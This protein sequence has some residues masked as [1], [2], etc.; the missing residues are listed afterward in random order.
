VFFAPLPLYPHANFRHYHFLAEGIPDIADALR[1]RNIGFV[2]R[3]FPEHS[4]ARFCEEVK[5][6]L[7]V[8]DENPLRE[9]E[10]WRVKAGKQLRVPLWTVD[11]DVIVPSKLLQKAQYAAHII[12]PRLQALLPT[13]LV[14]ATGSGD[15][16]ARSGFL[17]KAEERVIPRSR[18]RPR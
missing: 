17:A 18:V 13:F 12:R 7:V 8:G 2:P 15:K 16:S 9:P 4:L 6:A 14:P 3:R 10:A 5:A 1:E 11:A